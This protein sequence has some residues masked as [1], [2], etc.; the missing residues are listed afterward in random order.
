MVFDYL[1]NFWGNH[2][3]IQ[4]DDMD[5]DFLKA[6]DMAKKKAMELA[7][8]PMLLSWYCGKTKEY[9]PKLECGTWDKPVWIIFAESRGA[10]IAV[11]INGGEY[12]F[13]YLSF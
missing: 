10:D 2:I 8:D 6:K 1:K 11:S 9:Y 13:L 12:V 7:P 3:E 5:L 4:L